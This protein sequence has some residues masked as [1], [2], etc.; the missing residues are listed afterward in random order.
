MSA[1]PEHKLLSPLPI[2]VEQWRNV[3]GFPNYRVSD[4]GRVQSSYGG[5]WRLRKP[6]T[7]RDGYLYVNLS[8]DN[9]PHT[10]RIHRLVLLAFVGAPHGREAAHFNGDKRD[11]SLVNLR[12]ATHA[13]NAHDLAVHGGAHRALGSSNGLA[14]LTE[15]GVREIRRLRAAGATLRS[16]GQRFGVS[17]QTISMIAR[18]R[19]WGHVPTEQAS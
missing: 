18:G 15:D 10:G 1:A 14:K 4:L 5:T 19:M 6:Q 11:N 12:W 16:I 3:P 8:R 17:Q 7:D 13:E 2:E 9:K